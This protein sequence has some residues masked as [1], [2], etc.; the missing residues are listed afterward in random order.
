MTPSRFQKQIRFLQ[1]WLSPQGYAGLHLT[2][3]VLVVLICG[4]CFGEIAEDV[5]HGDPIVQVDRHVAVWF[6]QHASPAVTQVARTISFFGSV[7]W[8]AAVSV[9]VVLFLIW[10]GDHL[11]ASLV[12]LVMVGGST[13]NVIVKHF[14]HRERPVLEN[15]LVTLSSYG[16]PSGHTMGATLFYG[17]LALFAWK[18]VRNRTARLACIVG[19]CIWILL[20]GLTRIYLG[21]HYLTDVLGALAAGLLWLVFCWTAF[22]TLH[23]RR[24]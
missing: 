6:H 8:L 10:R 17:L 16:F 4:W 20:I 23:R 5:S 11:N 21:A 13:L 15:P 2:V 19:A 12:A 7:G 3:G 14:F 22:E 18:N 9:A 24:D 1:N